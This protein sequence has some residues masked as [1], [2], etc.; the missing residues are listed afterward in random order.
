MLAEV[1]DVHGYLKTP[2]D[3]EKCS[4]TPLVDLQYRK[5]R[6]FASKMMLL[7]APSDPIAGKLLSNLI[8]AL[9]STS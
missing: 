7:E 2:S 8:E 1:V 6:V 3:L 4:G 5:G 9:G